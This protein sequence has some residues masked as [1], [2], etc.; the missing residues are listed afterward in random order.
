[1]E[2]ISQIDNKPARHKK[3]FLYRPF[4]EE[5]LKQMQMW[6]QNEKWD[7]VTHEASAHKKMAILQNILLTKYFKQF[8]E[9]QKTITSDDEPFYT[10]KL[11]TLKRKKSR[12]FHKKR[13]SEKWQKLNDDYNRELEMAKKSYYNKKIRKL[14]KTQSKYWSREL[15]KL[16][17]FDQW[18]SDDLIV[19][20][21]KELSEEE[22]AEK[23]ADKFAAVSQEFDEIVATD[24]DIPEFSKAEIPEISVQEVKENMDTSKSNVNNDIPARI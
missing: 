18:K 6:M 16:T 10:N 3:T 7:E 17:S 9:T 23:I 1:M 22:Q 8:P 15:K 19:E 24:V 4:T 13:K 21:I 20:E 12:E 11:K 2:P 14:R 5:R